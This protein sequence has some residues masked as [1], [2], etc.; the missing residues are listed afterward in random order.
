MS[1]ERKIRTPDIEDS[2]NFDIGMSVINYTKKFFSSE[3]HYGWR[4]D[5]DGGEDPLFNQGVAALVSEISTRRIEF[6]YV[7]YRASYWDFLLHRLKD[8]T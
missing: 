5:E 6:V 4:D 2:L 7:S 1:S 3:E 8:S